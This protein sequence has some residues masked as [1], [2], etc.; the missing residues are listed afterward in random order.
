MEDYT[1]QTCFYE[2]T[3][4]GQASWDP[5]SNLFLTVKVVREASNKKQSNLGIR[6]EFPDENLLSVRPPS[7]KI[8]NVLNV[9]LGVQ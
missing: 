8:K 3:K 6:P 5:A 4:L 7:N 9:L 1:V 2:S